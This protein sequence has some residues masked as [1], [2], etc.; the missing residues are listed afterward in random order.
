MPVTTFVALI[1]AVLAS[2]GLTVW[3]FVA[4]G[5]GK[6][7]PLLLALALLGRWALSSAPA[8]DGRA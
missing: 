3:A 4:W 6:V 8:D 2:A 5:A 1:I 7:I